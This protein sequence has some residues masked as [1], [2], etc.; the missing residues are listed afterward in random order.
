M[1]LGG[2]TGG[3]PARAASRFR[4]GISGARDKFIRFDG[5]AR[6]ME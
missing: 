6:P 5:L 1:F 3:L 2:V 4:H